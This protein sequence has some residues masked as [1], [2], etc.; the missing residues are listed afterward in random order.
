[1]ESP[2]KKYQ[3]N[4]RKRPN[5]KKE[6]Y[7]YFFEKYFTDP[8][9][10]N[11]FLDTTERLD[12]MKLMQFL[13]GKIYTFQYNPVYRDILD[14]YDKRPII[15]CCG[16]WKASTGNTIVTGINLNFLPETARVN[17]LEYY[18]Q[19]IKSE[20]DQA[21]DETERTNRVS[22]LKRAFLILQDLVSLFN[23]FNRAGQIG[24]QFAMRNYIVGNSTMRQ[25]VLVEYDDWEWI[26]FLQTQEVVGKS[27]GEIHAEYLKQKSALAK[28]QPPITG[29]GSKKK[30]DNR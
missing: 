22:F 2:A 17:T 19:G 16:Q 30:Y 15:L 29:V 27:L 13:P 9:V 7:N 3:D 18:Y 28:K 23:I 8:Y 21:Y 10:D 4:L 11:G 20:L 5:M 14:Y 24:Y 26:P 6:A 12:A 1:M 25:N